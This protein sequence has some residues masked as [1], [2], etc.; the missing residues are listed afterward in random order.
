MEQCS[1]V[2]NVIH[3][4]QYNNNPIDYYNL[5]VRTPRT[6]NSQENVWKVRRR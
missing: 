3:Y 6:K 5:D 4:V 2:S 1:V